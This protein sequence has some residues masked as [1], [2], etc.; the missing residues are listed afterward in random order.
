M[1]FL[2]FGRAPDRYDRQWFDRLVSALEKASLPE[3]PDASGNFAIGNN[4]IATT[5]TD[6]FLYLPT[7]AGVPTG[8]PRDITGQAPLV[9]DTTTGRLHAYYGGAWH[10]VT[11]T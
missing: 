8:T 6:G 3:V 2:R 1:R 9:I 4:P 5:A 11:L 10:F 7:M